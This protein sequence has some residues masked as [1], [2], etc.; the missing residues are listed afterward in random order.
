MARRKTA[1]PAPK[2]VAITTKE[3][4]KAIASAEVQEQFHNFFSTLSRPQQDAVRQFIHHVTTTWLSQGYRKVFRFLR[5]WT[6][7]FTNITF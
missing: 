5:R 7:E 1:S 3:G 4:E 2:F 6:A